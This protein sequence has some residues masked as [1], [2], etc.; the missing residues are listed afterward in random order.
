MWSGQRAYYHEQLSTASLL[1][2][3]YQGLYAINLEKSDIWQL[4]DAFAAIFFLDNLTQVKSVI[5]VDE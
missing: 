1:Y 5:G 3:L 2:S 4:I